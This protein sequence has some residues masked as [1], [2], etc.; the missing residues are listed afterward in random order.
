VKINDRNA[1]IDEV[2][3]DLVGGVALSFGV[4]EVLEVDQV[5]PTTHAARRARGARVDRFRRRPP[6]VITELVGALVPLLAQ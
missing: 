2:V 5:P 1:S 4:V 3:V 6:D